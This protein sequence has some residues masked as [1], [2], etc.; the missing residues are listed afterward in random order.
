[1]LA[2][3]VEVRVATR[4]PAPYLVGAADIQGVR[5]RSDW[6]ALIPRSFIGE[7]LCDG[8]LGP[9]GAALIADFDGIETVLDLGTGSGCLAIL[10]A[11]SFVNALVDAVDNSPSALELAALNVTDHGLGDRIRL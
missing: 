7:M 11:H 10:A 4:K 6:R 9:D 8:S 3:I 5:F 2:A 1:R